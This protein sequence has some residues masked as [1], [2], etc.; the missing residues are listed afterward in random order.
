VPEG[1]PASTPRSNVEG[2]K[3]FLITLSEKRTKK[4]SK[5]YKTY[6]ANFIPMNF[7]EFSELL[8]RLYFF[9]SAGLNVTLSSSLTGRASSGERR[10]LA[11]RKG[12]ASC[13]LPDSV[14]ALL[15]T[16]KATDAS[17]TRKIRSVKRNSSSVPSAMRS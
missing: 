1:T 5:I 3:N 6:L 8:F 12:R 4:S 2:L 13:R 16:W 17:G 15:I 14:S 11:T 9:F 10:R 7:P